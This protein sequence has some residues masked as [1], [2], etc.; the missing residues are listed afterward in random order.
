[1]K[2]K[3]KAARAVSLT[4]SPGEEACTQVLLA[5][6]LLTP[7]IAEKLRIKEGCYTEEG[8]PRHLDGFPCPS[9]TIDGADVQLDDY[10][11]RETK[12]HKFR[13]KQ[14]KTGGDN[15]V[16]L[17]LTLRIHFEG[18]VPLFK[19][20]EDVGKG[21]FVL[22][23]NARQED[24][25]FDDEA[26]AAEEVQEEIAFG[27]V[28]CENDVPLGIGNIHTNGQPCKAVEA[29]AGPALASAPVLAASASVR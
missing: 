5:S 17:E 10:L 15:D 28:S 7:P 25:A 2:L 8:V 27:C 16:S 29:T 21:E 19:W 9:I 18:K 4:K 13:V 22:G 23:I 6:A 14:P 24:L 11:C 26:E 20:L 3:L 1:M 12:I